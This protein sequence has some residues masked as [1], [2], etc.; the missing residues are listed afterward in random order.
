MLAFSGLLLGV[1]M[2]TDSDGCSGLPGVLSLLFWPD[3]MLRLQ[4][5]ET[6]SH[7]VVSVMHIAEGNT[8]MPVVVSIWAGKGGSAL[9]HAQVPEILLGK[10]FLVCLSGRLELAW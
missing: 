7:V 10:K 1:A 3:C 5:A 8:S 2:A 4:R 6:P 9:V